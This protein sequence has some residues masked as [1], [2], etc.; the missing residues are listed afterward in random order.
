MENQSDYFIQLEEVLSGNSTNLA[1]AVIWNG[2]FYLWHLGVCSDI[3]TAIAKAESLLSSG[4]V[5]QK[6]KEIQEILVKFEI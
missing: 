6:R 4:Q 3:S 5:T 2:A 1:K